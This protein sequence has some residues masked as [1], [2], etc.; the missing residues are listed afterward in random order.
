MVWVYS[1]TVF[2]ELNS[3][4]TTFGNSASANQTADALA[5]WQEALRNEITTRLINTPGG[6]LGDVIVPAIPNP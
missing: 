2:I 3:W 4:W 1:D 6:N 5:A